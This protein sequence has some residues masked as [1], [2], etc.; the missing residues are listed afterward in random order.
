MVDEIACAQETVFRDA[1]GK[2]ID[3][4]AARAGARV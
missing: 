2:K 4:K 1:T 3:M